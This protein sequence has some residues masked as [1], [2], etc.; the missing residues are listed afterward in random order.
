MILFVD[1]VSVQRLKSNTSLRKRPKTVPCAIPFT[2]IT[3]MHT[4]VG[5]LTSYVSLSAA[6][7]QGVLYVPMFWS[8]YAFAALAATTAAIAIKI[9]VEEK[10]L[11]GDFSTGPAYERYK[12]KVPW[13]VIPYLW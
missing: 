10:I 5:K 8:Y 7:M 1:F 4:L 9:P 13:R 2:G 3:Y 11:E 6:L 12:E